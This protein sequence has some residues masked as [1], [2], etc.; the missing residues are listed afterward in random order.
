MTKKVRLHYRCLVLRRTGILV[1]KYSIYFIRDWYIVREQETLLAL[2]ETYVN[3]SSLRSRAIV[4]G[5]NQICKDRVLEMNYKNN[6][7]L[8]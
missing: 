8:E 7:Y 1:V 2:L 5:L 4:G 3:R 6:L